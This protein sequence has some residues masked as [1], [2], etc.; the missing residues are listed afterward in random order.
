M[1]IDKIQNELLKEALKTLKGKP[2][3]HVIQYDEEA[4]MIYVLNGYILHLIPSKE[5]FLDV[6]MLQEL[7][8]PMKLES[9][10]QFLK[11]ANEGETAALTGERRIIVDKNKKLEVAKIQGEGEAFAWVQAKYL[12][13]FEDDGVTFKIT[14]WKNPVYVYEFGELVA[15]V[16]PVR[17][18]Q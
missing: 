10:K 1:K 5:F 12:K 14:A 13:Y 11:N 6:D 8:R 17:V 18:E 2:F 15:M 7:K 16:M 4:G 3:E 9:I